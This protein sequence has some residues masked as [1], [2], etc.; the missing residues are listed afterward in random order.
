MIIL[1]ALFYEFL[2]LLTTLVV[3]AHYGPDYTPPV[4]SSRTRALSIQSQQSTSSDPYDYLI[5]N[6]GV[7]SRWVDSDDG[8]KIKY[9]I[10]PEYMPGSFSTNQCRYA[11]KL[12]FQAWTDICGVDFIFRG[13]I[14]TK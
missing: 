6:N 13:F 12:A 9:Y 7:P 4:E 10:D 5:Q 1:R 11:A 3:N 2:L 8:S 14:Y